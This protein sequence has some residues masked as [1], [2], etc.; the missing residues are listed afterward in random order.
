MVSGRQALP[1][2]D[3]TLYGER[4]LLALLEQ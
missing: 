1:N 2:Y 4:L 3:T